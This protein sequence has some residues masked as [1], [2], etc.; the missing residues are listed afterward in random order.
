[1]QK[2]KL[3]CTNNRGVMSQTYS[4]ALSVAAKF[5]A[6]QAIQN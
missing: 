2:E 5:G 3:T 6:K 1:M 4:K